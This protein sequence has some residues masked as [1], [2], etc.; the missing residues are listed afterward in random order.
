MVEIT[1]EVNLHELRAKK[2]ILKAETHVLITWAN[3][4]S[5]LF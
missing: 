3:V 5:E 4:G 1:L 2:Y